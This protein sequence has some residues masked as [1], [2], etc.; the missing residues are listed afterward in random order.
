MFN[1]R[2]LFVFIAFF[3]FLGI[4]VGIITDDLVLATVDDDYEQ[5]RIF[6][7]VFNEIKRKYVEDVP[8]SDM[9]VDAINGM[10]EGLDPHTVFLDP[11]N[12][13]ELMIDTRGKFE[14]L[15]IVISLRE[16]I[17]TVITPIEGTP[18]YELGI[19]AGDR[20]LQIEG[21]STRGV[22]LVEA[23]NS[24]RGPK[25]TE[26]TIS[27]LREGMDELIDYTVTRDVIEI[28][29]VPFYGT[30]EGNIGYIRL[31]NFSEKA[32]EE[33][34]HA[35]QELNAQ[36]IEGMILDLRN[37]FGGV[38]EQAVEVADK[39][40]DK[41]RLIVYYKG[42]G[43]GN[44]RE[45]YGTHPVATGE[46]PLVVLINGGTASASEIVA[47]AIQD[48]D[49]GLITGTRSF[50]KGSVQSIVRLSQGN[51]LKLTTAYYYTNSGRCI[52][53]SEF[54]SS[55]RELLN[56]AAGKEESEQIEEMTEE[57]VYYTN[58]GRLVY[59]GGGI[60]PD[61][62][63]EPEKS[64]NLSTEILRNYA[65]FNF[66]IQYTIQHPDIPE[67]FEPDEQV[68]EEFND[69]LREKEIEFTQTEFQEELD[70]IK[71]GIKQ[72]II[73]KLYGTTTAYRVTIHSDP[74]IMKIL[75][76]LDETNSMDEL[77]ATYHA[78][79][80]AEEIV[81]EDSELEGKE[82]QEIQELEGTFEFS[83]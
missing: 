40:I 64:S 72:K 36:H 23:V 33:I 29:S 48:W 51:A 74:Q 69:Y 10:L 6:S 77:L 26:V 52:N 31:A 65:F 62:L 22:S 34:D 24:L 81:A 58:S 54:Q 7:E 43:K 39:F 59:G 15:G 2:T 16:D 57:E 76:I 41:D 79:P 80:P 71:N 25:G 63:I 35:I 49:Q 82:L 47:G 5:L 32:A 68:L 20:I 60:Y 56:T 13:E 50:G 66:A 46:Y 30:L 83:P 19:Q 4:L 8:S 75:D 78:T 42:R 70:F 73:S 37:N 21:E 17:L 45:F 67:T 28:P 12:Y 55:K 3:V 27:I 38:L 1:T 18:A 53:R 44:Y 14:G 61:Y 11:R 9:I